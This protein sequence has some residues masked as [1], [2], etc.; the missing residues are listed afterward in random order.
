M[1]EFLGL[2][3]LLDYPLYLRGIL[4]TLYAIFLFRANS[5]RIF[6]EHSVL[7]LIISIILGAILGEA[8]VNNI[9]LLPS[10]IV[11]AFIVIIHRFL[12]YLSF[13]SSWFGRYIKGEKVVLYNSQGY[14]RENLKCC[15]IT[16]NDVLQALRTQRGIT[17]IDD[18]KEATLE[19]SGQ[20]SFLM[21]AL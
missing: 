12:A 6:G 11:C 1:S 13:K 16:E 7:D 2:N 17:R 21:K 15:R 20:I 18:V 3:E 4:I 19:R 14:C 10:M 5:S 8:I 9:P